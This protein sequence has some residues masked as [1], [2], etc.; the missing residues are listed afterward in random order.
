MPPASPRPARVDRALIDRL[1]QRYVPCGRVARGFVRWKLR[2]DPVHQAIFDAA[3]AA[4]D[5]APFG[6]VLDLGCG[7]GQF[8][9]ALLEA[10]LAHEATG[11]DWDA[12]LIDQARRAAPGLPARFAAADLRQQKLPVADTTL[13]VD[14]LYQL[15]FTAQQDLVRRA[16]AATRERLF[17]RALDPER[18]WRSRVGRNAERL[19]R[20]VRLY[21]KAEIAPTPVTTF[22]GWLEQA[23]FACT[24]R[25]CW[26][27]TPFPN[28]LLVASRSD[29][30]QNG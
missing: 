9:L 22:K 12:P 8:A 28:V 30:R 2:L 7:R 26:G 13:L 4:S 5:T 1:E 24:V 3:D 21:R 20:L 27:A 19:S 17:I 11:F 18:G 29:R 23:G 16:A 15:D 6:H 25:P 10:G 14:L